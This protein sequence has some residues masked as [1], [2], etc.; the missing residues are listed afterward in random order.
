MSVSLTK[1]RARVRERL[2]DLDGHQPPFSSVKVDMAMCSAWVLL[3]AQ[4]PPPILQVAYSDT[5]ALTIA[6]GASTFTLPV[7]ITSSGYGT[8][9]VEYAGGI[10]IQLASNGLFLEPLANVEMDAL[11]HSHALIPVSIP[12]YFSLYPDGSQ[13][14]RGRCYPA[15]LAAQSCNLWS[16]LRAQDLRNYV[17]TGGT[18]GLDSVSIPATVE[19]AQALEAAASKSLLAGMP[20]TAAEA[21]GLDKASL[22]LEW[23][24]EVET[25]LHD[26]EAKQANVAATGRPQRWTV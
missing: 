25:L 21:R 7:T 23:A 13:V 1:L 18:D 5:N 8:G 19:A 22:M 11:L 16:T 6:A 3:A 26:D 17:G 10:K 14:I 12:M 2:N 20:A 4:L 24:E 15:S 9:T